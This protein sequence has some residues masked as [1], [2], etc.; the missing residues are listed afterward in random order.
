MSLLTKKVKREASFLK[1]FFLLVGFREAYFFLK[2]CW[3]MMTHPQLTTGKILSKKDFSQAA[4]V[5]GLPFT[6]WAL[7]LVIGLLVWRLLRPSGILFTLGAG[8]FLLSGFFLFLVALYDLYWVFK[9]L[10]RVG[11]V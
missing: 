11:R 9:Y 3:G 5:F 4:L 7:V 1:R 8:F 2:N 6:L 10:R